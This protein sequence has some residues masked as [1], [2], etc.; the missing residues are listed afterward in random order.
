MQTYRLVPDIAFHIARMLIG[1]SSNLALALADS[2]SA[3]ALPQATPMVSRVTLVY[4]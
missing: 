2:P 1:G 4:V 3:A